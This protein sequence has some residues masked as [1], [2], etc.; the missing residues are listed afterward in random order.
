MVI[1]FDLFLPGGVTDEVGEIR[2]HRSF[3]CTSRIVL[4]PILVILT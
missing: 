3:P 1:L 4:E 2:V